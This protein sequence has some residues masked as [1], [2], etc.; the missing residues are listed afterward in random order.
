LAKLAL[1]W[2]LCLLL[3]P[4]LLIQGWWTRFKTIRLPEASGASYEHHEA[5]L[6]ILGMGEST[7]AGVG[8]QIMDQALTARI[9]H[10]LTGQIGQAVSW[11]AF[12]HNGDRLKDLLA[13]HQTL[14]PREFDA[15]VVAIGVND[16]TGLTSLLPWSRQILDLT[17]KLKDFTSLPDSS[18]TNN[19]WP[20]M[21]IIPQRRAT[22]SG[23]GL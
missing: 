15:V 13:K 12:G 4:L 19:T 17:I 23:V 18:L 3:F 5:G 16:A 14:P 2:N 21:A 6:S 22:R 1:L 11:D 9:A 10:S 7:I 20:A 8:V